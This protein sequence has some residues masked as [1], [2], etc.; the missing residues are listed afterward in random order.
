M[1]GRFKRGAQAGTKVPEQWAQ[2]SKIW[3]GPLG[4]EPVAVYSQNLEREPAACSVERIRDPP[5]DLLRWWR[6][7]GRHWCLTKPPHQALR[8]CLVPAVGELRRNLVSGLL[9]R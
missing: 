2:T 7:E 6:P 9:G 3:A 8:A 1:F 5:L 4:N